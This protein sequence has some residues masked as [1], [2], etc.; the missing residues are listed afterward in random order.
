MIKPISEVH[1]PGCSSCTK[2]VNLQ[3][4]INE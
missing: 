3:A 4:K 2:K 1:S